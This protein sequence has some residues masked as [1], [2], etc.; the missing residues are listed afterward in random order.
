[1]SQLIFP[2]NLIFFSFFFIL[3]TDPPF[4]IPRHRQ[5]VFGV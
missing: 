4:S 3:Y 5:V 2:F 1:M